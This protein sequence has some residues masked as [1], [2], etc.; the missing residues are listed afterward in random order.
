MDEPRII[1]EAQKGSVAAFNQ[2]VMAYQGMAY[3]VAY[4]VIGQR[5]AAAD[6]CQDAFLKA[7]QAIQ[8][9]H[10][11][12][13]KSWLMRIVTNT[14][15]DQLR[16]KSRRPAASLDDL[17]DNPN[18]H[19]TTLVN[20]AEQPEERMLRGEL[21]DL[22]QAGIG[23]LPA[24]QRLVLVLSDV[25]G[26]SYQEIADIIDQ[27]VGTVKSRLSRGRQRLRDFLM[28]KK[29]LLPAQYRLTDK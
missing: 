19:N 2:L 3:N 27:P 24:D 7:Y 17:T 20:G 28:A 9:Y 25:Q 23:Q 6:A 16:Y 26:F 15:Y 13:F 29:E 4:R 14:C 18:E 10:G 22:I 21:G 12:S 11:G 8:Q 1:K 5:E